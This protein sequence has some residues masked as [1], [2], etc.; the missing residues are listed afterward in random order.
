LLFRK[1]II[2]AHLEFIFLGVLSRVRIMSICVLTF[3]VNSLL[4]LVFSPEEGSKLL[5]KSNVFFRKF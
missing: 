3:L 1:Q 2:G 5:P 4:G